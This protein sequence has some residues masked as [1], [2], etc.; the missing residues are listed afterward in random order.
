MSI[1]N[2]L[3]TL[4]DFIQLTN[5][6]GQFLLVST[7]EISKEFLKST[8][9]IN[10]ITKEARQLFNLDHSKEVD[11]WDQID[12]TLIQVRDKKEMNSAL[13]LIVN[14]FTTITKWNI[15]HVLLSDENGITKCSG[16]WSHLDSNFKTSDFY[17][18]STK[19]QFEPGKGLPGRVY[20][21]KNFE[22]IENVVL[23]KNFPRHKAAGELHIVSGIGIPI[24]TRDKKVMAIIE[25][26]AF[27]HENADK[28]LI[29]ALEQMGQ[30]V[31]AK[32]L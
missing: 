16:I 9:E 19:A 28:D 14:S 25:F 6:N 11:F 23:D 17:S 4:H 30:I 21:S 8:D 31:G 26:F 29:E 12:K 2:N 5:K 13:Q 18:M 27:T 32:S 20:Q 15:G 7:S 24:L 22:Y 3:N 10:S 1:N